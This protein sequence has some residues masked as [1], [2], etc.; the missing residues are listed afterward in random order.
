MFLAP[1]EFNVYSRANTNIEMRSGR[2]ERRALST[3]PGRET[4]EPAGGRVPLVGRVGRGLL[5]AGIARPPEDSSETLG[6]EN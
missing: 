2:H 4:S 5:E 3:Q 6:A 1:R